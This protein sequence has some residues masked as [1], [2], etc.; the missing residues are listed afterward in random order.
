MSRYRQRRSHCIILAAPRPHR[1][2]LASARNAPNMYKQKTRR[3]RVGGPPTALPANLAH[4]SQVSCGQ[5]HGKWPYQG[6]TCI[7]VGIYI[8]ICI[9]REGGRER[10][11]ERERLLY[12]PYSSLDMGSRSCWLTRNRSTVAVAHVAAASSPLQAPCRRVAVSSHIIASIAPG[13]KFR[14]RPGYF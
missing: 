3:P 12:G 5:Y 11:R 2:Y 6:L 9:H 14:R 10:E 8:Y 1:N 7:H 4:Q 13:M